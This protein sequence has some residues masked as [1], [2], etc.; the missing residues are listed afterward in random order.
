VR[1]TGARFGLADTPLRYAHI[2]NTAFNLGNRGSIDTSQEGEFTI[3]FWIRGDRASQ[4]IVFAMADDVVVNA[5]NV[6]TNEL[7]AVFLSG[8]MSRPIASAT[9]FQVYFAVMISG[10]RQVL[11]IGRGAGQGPPTIREWT[12]DGVELTSIFDSNWHHIAIT[13]S[14]LLSRRYLRLYF[15]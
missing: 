3:T 8:D 14:A 7:L 13:A 12:L 15:G 10:A 6:I 2:H 11:A 1:A 9:S 4:G 5:E